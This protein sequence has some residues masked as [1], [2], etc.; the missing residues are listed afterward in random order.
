[1]T[2]PAYTVRVRGV[3]RSSREY[4]CPTH[5]AFDLV[6]DLATSRDPRPCPECGAASERTLE[7]NIVAR[8]A[9]TFK[10]GKRDEMSP[11]AT[12]TEAIADGMPVEEWRSQRAKLWENHDRKVMRE[13]GLL[14]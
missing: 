1:M 7:A 13:K 5:G 11:L 10:R 8:V 14:P 12:T 3:E 2:A 6:V 9:N 4:L